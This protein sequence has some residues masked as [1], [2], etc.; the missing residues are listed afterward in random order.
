M[1]NQL[2]EIQIIPIKPQNGLV[3]FASF[4]WDKASIWLNRDYDPTTRRL[5]AVFPYKKSSRA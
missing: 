5:Q 3:A 4:V 1:T 2:S